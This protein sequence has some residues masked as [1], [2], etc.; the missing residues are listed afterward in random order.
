[1]SKWLSK[2][3]AGALTAALLATACAHENAA[4][5]TTST[6]PA[7]TTT[8]T[9]DQTVLPGV[10]AFLPQPPANRGRLDL[11]GYRTAPGPDGS[12][13]ATVYFRAPAVTSQLPPGMTGPPPC[14]IA[15]HVTG[16]DTDHVTVDIDL[17]FSA[18]STAANAIMA[19]CW[20]G[21]AH[22]P[23]VR[24]YMVGPVPATAK[25]FT[26]APAPDT[27]LPKLTEPPR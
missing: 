13:I 23:V 4:A 16:A 3:A 27:P 5:P 2:T 10:P 6:T 15:P 19:D 9:T 12:T 8:T 25:L 21:D 22:Q 17:T 20:T 18:N 1:M 26:G 11:I 14:D 7:T 24:S